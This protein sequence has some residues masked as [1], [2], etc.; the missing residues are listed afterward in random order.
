MSAGQRWNLAAEL[1][2]TAAELQTKVS[3]R[4]GRN[5]SDPAVASA[6]EKVQDALGL[7]GEAVAGLTTADDHEDDDGDATAS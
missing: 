2:A 7:L 1:S 5:L 4:S 3:A 6:L